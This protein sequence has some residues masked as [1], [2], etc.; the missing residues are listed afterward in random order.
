MNLNPQLTFDSAAQLFISSHWLITKRWMNLWEL[1]VTYVISMIFLFNSKSRQI[2][3]VSELLILPRKHC[4][5]NNARNICYA[6]Q[7]DSRQILKCFMGEWFLI[8]N[9]L[10]LMYHQCTINHFQHL[11]KAHV[12]VIGSFQKLQSTQYYYKSCFLY[13]RA[14][15]A[16]FRMWYFY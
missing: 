10:C 2:N 12:T 13:V 15:K 11:K 16:R 8:F 1:L 9:C 7:L 5:Y 3:P 4:N 6:L 14:S